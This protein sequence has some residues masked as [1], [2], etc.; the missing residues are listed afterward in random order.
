MSIKG[1]TRIFSGSRATNTPG[2]A[3]L[4]PKRR[5]PQPQPP[6]FSVF[7]R[8]GLRFGRLTAPNCD[9]TATKR[10]DLHHEGRDT[11][12]TRRRV[13]PNGAKP[14]PPAWRAP[15]GPQG[16]TAALVGGTDTTASQ[17]SHVI[18]RGHFS[19]CHKN[20][21]IPTMQIQCL[22]ESSRNYV[23]NCWLTA[24]AGHQGNA[25]SNIS[26]EGPTGVEGAGGT[27]GPGRT[28]SRSADRSERCGRGAARPHGRARYPENLRVHKQQP[29][30]HSN[31]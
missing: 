21:A 11:P 9:L 30:P 1:L 20:V 13:A 18:Y 4:C 7:H 14:P 17:I 8:G 22:N 5:P 26:R 31:T 28:T 19:T 10:G 23:R 3:P 12:A 24:I 25:L 6:I 2:Q 16:L 29:A 15:E 27:A